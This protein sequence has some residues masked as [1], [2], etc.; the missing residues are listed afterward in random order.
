MG[1]FAP[2]FSNACELQSIGGSKGVQ[3]PPRPN[4]FE[5]H[6]IFGKIWQ[7]GMLAHPLEGGEHL[8]PPLQLNS[9]LCRRSGLTEFI[10]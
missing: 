9:R 4:F 2:R 7:S 1:S 10:D 5:F 6:A 3:A 8:D